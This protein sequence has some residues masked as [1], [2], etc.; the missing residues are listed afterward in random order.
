VWQIVAIVIVIYILVS[1]F[2]SIQPVIEFRH[3][4]PLIKDTLMQLDAA[5]EEDYEVV[6]LPDSC[7]HVEYYTK[8][9]CHGIRNSEEMIDLI[10]TNIKKGIITYINLNV[11][12]G[13]TKQKEVIRFANFLLETYNITEMVEGNVEDFHKAA[14]ELRIKNYN[15]LPIYP[16]D[17]PRTRNTSY[18]Y[19]DWSEAG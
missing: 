15:L 9:R 2:R 19:L 8:K 3:E 7:V 5:T 14:I 18:E 11:P 6:T 17:V 1:M 10:E 4:H 12:D 16:G 13:S